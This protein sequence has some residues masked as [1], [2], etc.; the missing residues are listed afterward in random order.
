MVFRIHFH[1][2]RLGGGYAMYAMVAKCV[3]DGHVP[4]NLSFRFTM[5][6]IRIAK[7]WSRLALKKK[8]AD[9]HCK[10]K[11]EKRSKLGLQR[12]REHLSRPNF[13]SDLL[14]VAQLVTN[15]PEMK[16]IMMR[17]F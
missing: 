15:R 1:F 13:F 3:T 8:G 4:S 17:W 10:K 6:Q 5:E 7:K 12:A 16:K 14:I 11:K 9:W 2:L